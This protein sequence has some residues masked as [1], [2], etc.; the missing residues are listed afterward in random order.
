M[1]FSS[2][3]FIVFALALSING[4]QSIKTELKTQAK[5]KEKKYRNFVFSVVD[6]YGAEIN[7]IDLEYKLIANVNASEWYKIEEAQALPLTK[8]EILLL[9]NK[10]KIEKSNITLSIEIPKGNSNTIDIGRILYSLKKDDFNIKTGSFIQDDRANKQERKIVMYKRAYQDYFSK[11]FLKTADN[12]L[13]DSIKNSIGKIIIEGYLG[14]SILQYS[15]IDKSSFKKNDYLQLKFDNQVVYN[16]LQLS[17][18]DIGKRLFDEVI[19]KTLNPLNVLNKDTKFYGYDITING[20]T[21]S[22]LDKNY[23]SLFNKI[24]HC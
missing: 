13:I 1:K 22:F 12:D 3:L 11:N 18:Y 16:S 21:K 23:L 15:S 24:R 6:I 2:I 17:K 20:Y 5:P 14:N 8:S 4:C 7:N 10:T 19:R 9:D